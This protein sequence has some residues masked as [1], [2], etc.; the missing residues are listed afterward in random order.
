MSTFKPLRLS[1]FNNK[2][3]TKE[4]EIVAYKITDLKDALVYEV[5]HSLVGQFMTTKNEIPPRNSSIAQYEYINDVVLD[6]L[7]NHEIGL[8]LPAQFSRHF[9]KEGKFN[10]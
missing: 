3:E 7:D 1:T 9:F 10:K 6:E 4:Q 5:E 2:V 8:L